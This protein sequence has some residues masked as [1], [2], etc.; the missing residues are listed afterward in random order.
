M[1]AKKHHK[2]FTCLWNDDNVENP[3][4]CECE[5]CRLVRKSLETNPPFLKLFHKAHLVAFENDVP[6]PDKKLM[7]A[8]PTEFDP[9]SYD[10]S[11]P[12]VQEILDRLTVQEL[13]GSIKPVCLGPNAIY[14]IFFLVTGGRIC[15]D[16][17][18][19][20]YVLWNK[21]NQPI[22]VE[23]ISQLQNKDNT[24]LWKTVPKER[25]FDMF[26]RIA[27][28]VQDCFDAYVRLVGKHANKTK[29]RRL[30]QR[31]HNFNE[32]PSVKAFRKDVASDYA[33]KNY[34]WEYAPTNLGGNCGLDKPAK[35]TRMVIP[36]IH[37]MSVEYHAFLPSF[38][39]R[40]KKKQ[41]ELT[42]LT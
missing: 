33:H 35:P 2:S 31:F 13:D 32:M 34:R 14:D 41:S 8:N 24:H 7:Q 4:I 29:S 28:S 10:W 1:I 36:P 17:N 9:E 27:E 12:E 21:D 42:F 26:Y 38:R 19:Q 16:R 18:K 39:K 30:K 6:F 25:A 40:R 15:A 5:R 23:N 22:T 11:P 20:L 3:E 37:K